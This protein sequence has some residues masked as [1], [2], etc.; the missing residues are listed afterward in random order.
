MGRRLRMICFEEKAL[1]ER[2]EEYAK[3]L[4]ISGWKYDQA[5]K[6]LKEGANI[7][8]EKVL[9]KHPKKKQKKWHG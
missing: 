5:L 9:K 3:Y 6:G 4:V 8:R 7:S 2:I 1:Q